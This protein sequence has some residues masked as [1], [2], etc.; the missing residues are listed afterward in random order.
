MGSE[1]KNNLITYKKRKIGEHR[2]E[3]YIV[4]AILGVRAGFGW[5]PHNP[6]FQVAVKWNGFDEVTWHSVDGLQNDRR[7]LELI[8]QDIC[9]GVTEEKT[10][11]FRICE[12]QRLEEME[13]AK[14]TFK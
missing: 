8:L 9:V 6:D 7:I 11:S 5:T 4:E 2:D 13:G 14:A 1:K 12:Q 3:V 10:C